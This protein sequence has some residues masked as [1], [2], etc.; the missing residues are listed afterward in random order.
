MGL[1]DGGF[2]LLLLLLLGLALRV[3]AR[4]SDWRV[5]PVVPPVG[6][7]LG[8]GLALGWAAVAGLVGERVWRQ[9]P[10]HTERPLGAGLLT[11]GSVVP[12]AGWLVLLPYVSALGLGGTVMALMSRPGPQD[13]V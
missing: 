5:L 7:L 10:I 1:V 2:L 8:L 4:W 9:R 6:L 11:L 3:V 12:V 13:Q